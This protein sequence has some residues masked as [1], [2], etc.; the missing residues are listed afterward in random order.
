[1]ARERGFKGLI[2]LAASAGL[3][4]AHEYKPDAIMLDI[5]AARSPTAAIVLE[6]LKH[7]PDT[8]HIPVHIMS[9]PDQRQEVL[10]AGAVGYIEKPVTAG[11]ARA[12][13]SSAIA[14]FIERRVKNLLV[15]EDDDDAARARSSS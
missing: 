9:A 6:H 3:A 13:R 12:R 5:A 10:R 7:H 4:L 2:A 15:V 14:T 8:R 1:M 11:G